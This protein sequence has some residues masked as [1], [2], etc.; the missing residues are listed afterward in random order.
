[1]GRLIH[2]WNEE[3]SLT[4][5]H[6]LARSLVM[7]ES[8][9]GQLYP[10]ILIARLVNL[11]IDVSAQRDEILVLVNQDSLVS[12]LKKM[13]RSSVFSVAKAGRASVD[14]MHTLQEV[15]LRSLK[16]EVVVSVHEHIA[17]QEYSIARVIVQEDFKK[18][19]LSSS[20][21]KI[22]FRSLP[23]LVI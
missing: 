17:V 9:I 5:L 3:R 21:R 13:S 4:A 14:P 22:A 16:N 23:L 7:M 12:S 1:M 15:S 20:S 10:A 8:L 11:E 19:S 6:P 18:L 2:F